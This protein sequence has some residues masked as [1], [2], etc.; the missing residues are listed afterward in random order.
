[1]HAL[2]VVPARRPYAAPVLGILD[3]WLEVGG[4]RLGGGGDD[5]HRRPERILGAGDSLLVEKGHHRLAERHR[6]DGEQAVPA[7][8]E[9]VDDD[10]RRLVLTP[11]LVMMEAL[12]DPELD[13]QPRAGGDHVLGALA[14]AA[15]RGVDDDGALA[16][17]GWVRV[18]LAEVD[19]RRDDL[20]VGHPANRVV[21]ADDAGAGVPCPVE[22][23]RRLAADVGAEEVHHRALPLGT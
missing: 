19:A 18:V 14:P 5:G 9:L 21:R 7:G 10:V 1:V 16:V 23:L 20:G 17:G 12:D 15:G 13:R 11:G 6:L 4:Q 2:D 22:L 8:V 3:Q